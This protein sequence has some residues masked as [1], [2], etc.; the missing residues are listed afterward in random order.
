[1]H[2]GVKSIYIYMLSLN[3]I[4]Y[5]SKR[6]LSEYILYRMVENA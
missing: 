4:T 3:I 2:E 5:C 6:T 1:M